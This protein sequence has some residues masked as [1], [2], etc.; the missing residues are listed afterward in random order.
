MKRRLLALAAAAVLLL[1]GCGEVAG[2]VVDKEFRAAYDEP[3]QDPQY[4]YICVPGTVYDPNTGT[5]RMTQNCRN[6]LTHYVTRIRHHPDR[7]SIQV[8]DEESDKR[9]WV[10]VTKTKYDSID[11]G[12]FFSNKKNQDEDGHF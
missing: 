6:V 10:E 7:W 2:P 12:D 4:Q 9:K 11:L 1:A 8:R 3:Y 5:T